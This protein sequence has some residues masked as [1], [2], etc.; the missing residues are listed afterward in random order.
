VQRFF[1]HSNSVLLLGAGAVLPVVAHVGR[2]Q[3]DDLAGFEAFARADGGEPRLAVGAYSEAAIQERQGRSKI[4]VFD[5]LRA[6][7]TVPNA[8]FE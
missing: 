5:D 8:G 2:N 3:H 7:F 4:E 1:Q 6:S